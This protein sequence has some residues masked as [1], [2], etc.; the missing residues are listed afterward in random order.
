M[1]SVCTVLYG[2]WYGVCTKKLY[3]N[4][5]K[6]PRNLLIDSKKAAE[7]PKSD[8]NYTHNESMANAYFLATLNPSLL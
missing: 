3:L 1:Q 6:L 8:W 5:Q 7:F 4:H 2:V